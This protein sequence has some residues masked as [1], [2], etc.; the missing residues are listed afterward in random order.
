MPVLITHPTGNEFFREASKGFNTAGSLQ[1]VYTSIAC[2]RG[3]LLYEL[4]GW[5][6]FSD[7]RRRTM[8]SNIKSPVHIH[9]WRETARL[10]AGKVGIKKLLQHETGVL[11]VDRVYRSLDKYVAKKLP[12][13]RRQG[14]S[15]VYAYEDGACYAFERAKEL[16]IKCAYDLPIGYWRCMHQMLAAEKELNPGWAVTLEGLK[17]SKK[18]LNRKDREIEL[19]DAVFV[20]S[21]FTRTTLK[22]YPGNLPPVHVIPYGFPTA[23]EKVYTSF[24]PPRKIRLLFVG[25]LSQRKGLSYL[26]KAVEGLE[27][28]IELTVVGRLPQTTC[29][30]LS[31]ELGK[32]RHISYCTARKNTGADA[33]T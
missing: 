28:N 1:S 21:S 22:S 2:F 5:K 4:G 8:D 13:E 10:L 16:N 32:Y 19:A 6:A 3:S 18:K 20:A 31:R 30:P 23:S 9:P 12:A 14:A 29:E 27:A 15:V 33:C 11:S 17:D 25:G 24:T 26:F 7:I